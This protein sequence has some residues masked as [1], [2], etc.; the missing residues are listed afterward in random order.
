MDEWGVVVGQ[1]RQS[2]DPWQSPALPRLYELAHAL[3]PAVLSGLGIRREDI[4]DLVSELL[5][6]KLHEIVASAEPRP[7]F[8]TCLRRKAI[9]RLRRKATRVVED[10][11]LDAPGEGQTASDEGRQDARR[12][13]EI[14]RSL[15]TPR[16]WDVVSAIHLEGVEREEVA[17]ALRTSR[18]NIDQIMRRARMK[19]KEAGL[20]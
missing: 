2:K 13:L 10:R 18:A 3:G 17:A 4:E 14:V 9:S 20:P 8:W 5:A 12:I 11:P 6:T 7:F 19:L 16:E 15:L 1:V